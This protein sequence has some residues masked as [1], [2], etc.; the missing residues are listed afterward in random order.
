MWRNT[1]K[2]LLEEFPLVADVLN[3]VA[4]ENVVEAAGG[5]VVHEGIRDLVTDARVL[6]N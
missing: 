4:G 5:E 3:A 2:D 1:H 6:R